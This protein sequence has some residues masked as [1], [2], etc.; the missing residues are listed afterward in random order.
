MG[1]YVSKEDRWV[2]KMTGVDVPFIVA[3]HKLD[4]TI[5]GFNAVKPLVENRNYKSIVSLF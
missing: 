1:G 5:L 2:K 3:T 4:D